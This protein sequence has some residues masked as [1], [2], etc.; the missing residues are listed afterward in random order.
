M[1]VPLAV[2][3]ACTGTSYESPTVN[4]RLVP[5]V[6]LRITLP[7]IVDPVMPWVVEAEIATTLP[8]S[9]RELPLTGPISVPP[10][11]V[12]AATVAAPSACSTSPRR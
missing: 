5:A 10:F 3:V 8:L 12:K 6:V 2:A 4:T 9:V 7:L 1:P 11:R